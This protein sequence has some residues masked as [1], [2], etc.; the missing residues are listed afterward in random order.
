MP[1]INNKRK[2]YFNVDAKRARIT[3]R[4]GSNNVAIGDAFQGKLIG[5]AVREWEYDGQPRFSIALDFSGNETL[6]FSA[7]STFARMV[8][9]RMLFAHRNGGIL[10]KTVKIT[11]YILK[12]TDRCCGAVAVGGVKVGKPTQDCEWPKPLTVKVGR[13]DVMDDSNVIEAMRNAISEMTSSKPHYDEGDGGDDLGDGSGDT[14]W[15]DEPTDVDPNDMPY[16]P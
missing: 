1:V 9:S 12:D 14:G 15:P 5:A 8:L 3:E 7:Q 4:Q 13:K 6:S 10:G 2:T 16:L 11:P